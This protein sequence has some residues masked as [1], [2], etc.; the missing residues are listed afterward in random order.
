MTNQ[1]G[2][3][4]IRFAKSETLL[5]KGYLKS[6]YQLPEPA[7][8]SYTLGSQILDLTQ[9]VNAYRGDRKFILLW[10]NIFTDD[11]H[12]IWNIIND[13]IGDTGEMWA[14]VD[15]GWNGSAFINSWIDIKGVPK[16]PQIV[17]Q[18]NTNG[19]I[20]AQLIFQIDNTSVQNDPASF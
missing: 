14:T 3:D 10:Q 2:I 1:Y 18:E 11:A 7:L 13:A 5:A 20:V 19:L 16:L 9:G 15:T 6:S 12:I 4:N 17:A 8:A